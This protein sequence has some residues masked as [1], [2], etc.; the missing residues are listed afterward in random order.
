MAL[1]TKRKSPRLTMVIGNVKNTKIGFTIAFKTA[2]TIATINDALKPSTA[3][4]PIYLAINT[5][6]IAVISNLIIIF[7][8][9]V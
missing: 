1:I 8:A 2:R 4:P 7:I 5:T 6:R 9:L 3:T